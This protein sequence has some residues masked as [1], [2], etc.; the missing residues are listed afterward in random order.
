MTENPPVQAYPNKTKSRIVFKIKNRLQ[1]RIIDFWN[2]EIVREW[3]RD[4]DKYKDGENV[5]KL[6]SAEVVLVILI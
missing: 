6:E 4:V 5:P 1:I 3:K 2:N